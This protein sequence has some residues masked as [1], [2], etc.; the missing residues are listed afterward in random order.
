MGYLLGGLLLL[1]GLAAT[2]V[3]RFDV[4]TFAQ[5]MRYRF[6]GPIGDAAT[7]YSRL[8]DPAIRYLGIGQVAIAGFMLWLAGQAKD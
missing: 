6:P 8:S 4:R 5:R 1:D 3:P 2:V 7:E